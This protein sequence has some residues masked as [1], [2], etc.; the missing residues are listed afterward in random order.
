M[1]PEAA[2]AMNGNSLWPTVSLLS[3]CRRRP[4]ADA[5]AG[6]PQRQCGGPSYFRDVGGAHALSAPGPLHAATVHRRVLRRVPAA[7]GEAFTA[8]S[9]GTV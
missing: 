4:G 9:T 1:R 8:A 5:T 7:I 3:G 2:S 6:A